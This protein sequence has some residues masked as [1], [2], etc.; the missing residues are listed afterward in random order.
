M[1]ASSK[2]SNR[3]R[4]RVSVVFAIAVASLVAAA[5]AW[6][7]PIWYVNNVVAPG[8]GGQTGSPAVTRT[9]NKACRSGNS[10]QAR[11]RYYQGSTIV[12]DTGVLWTYCEQGAVAT[13]NSTGVYTSWC[14]HEGT[15]QWWLVCETTQP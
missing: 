3:R 5:V 4:I 1:G 7:G 6:A 15:V 8:G 2:R 11:A 13:N 12:S 14:R 9:Y 10:G